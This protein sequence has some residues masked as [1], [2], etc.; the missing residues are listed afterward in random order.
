LQPLSD[1]VLSSLKECI[2]FIDDEPAQRAII[3]LIRHLQIQRS[4]LMDYISVARLND[5]GHHALLVEVEHA[6]YDAAEV[7]ARTSTLFPFSRGYAGGSFT[8]RR[9]RIYEA[10]S[11]AGCFEDYDGIS[12]LADKWQ[13]ETSFQEEVEQ[14]QLF[15]AKIA[16]M[17]A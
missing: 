1:N 9:D 5:G 4:R 12:V 2:E 16:S 6:M 13:R 10:L 17:L 7:H 11:L 15:G 14:R 8:V 3:S